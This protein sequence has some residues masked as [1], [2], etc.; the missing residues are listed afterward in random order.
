[1]LDFDVSKY[2]S[3][4]SHA[5]TQAMLHEL[6]QGQSE[7]MLTPRRS[8]TTPAPPG[9]PQ[10]TATA[11]APRVAGRFV[12]MD[13]NDL[14]NFVDQNENI[15]TKKKTLCHM[16]LFEHF[17]ND[18]NELRQMHQIPTTE[19]DSHLS[20]FLICVRQKDGSEYQPSYLRG[21]LG[22][23]ERYL[24]RHRYGYS[25]IS[26][27]QFA[28]TREALKTKQ[29]DLKK[30]G[31][32]NK[33]MAAD[34]I[35]DSEINT[36]YETKQLGKDTPESL[37]NTVWFNNMLHFGMRGGDEH[38]Q[39]CWGDLKLGYDQELEREF[40]QFNERQT[41]TRTGI[42][43]TNTRSTKPAMY[44]EPGSDKCP[45]ETYKAYKE[46]RPV[47]FCDDEHPFYLGTVTHSKTPHQRDQWFLRAPVGRNKLFKLMKT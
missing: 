1:M 45:V 12:N 20:K 38:R 19:L 42:D 31:M 43:V 22:S 44:A 23:F 25:L 2:L 10:Q 30:K 9:S 32:G 18:V 16:K 4:I 36:L 33:P 7:S 17:L 35:T 40:L 41:K 8:H 11:T 24:K 3:E 28:G 46:K 29:K 13:E 27:H 26:S 14:R 5:E 15:N 39:L 6:E 37:L 34:V 47:N 21:M